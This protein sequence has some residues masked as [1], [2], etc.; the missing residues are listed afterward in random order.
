MVR[1]CENRNI[2]SQ[3][4]CKV[5]LECNLAVYLKIENKH[6]LQANGSISQDTLMHAYKLY[7]QEHP[8]ALFVFGENG[9]NA[10][11]CL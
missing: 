8:L 1:G 5:A 7:G 4:K 9:N 3:W 11:T 6:I 2:H 10:N